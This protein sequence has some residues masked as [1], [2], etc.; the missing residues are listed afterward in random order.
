MFFFI[1]LYFAVFCIVSCCAF[2]VLLKISEKQTPKGSE[3]N[4]PGWTKT[5][6]KGCMWASTDGCMQLGGNAMAGQLRQIV[7][8]GC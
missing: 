3:W 7:S 5:K 8:C 2:A 6:T 1:F 4:N